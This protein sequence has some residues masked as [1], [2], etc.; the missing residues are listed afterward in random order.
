MTIRKIYI[1]LLLLTLAATTFAQ[2]LLV[3]NKNGLA[4]QWDLADSKAKGKALF[5]VK[6]YKPL[7]LLGK[8]SSDVNRMPQSDSPGRS[9]TEEIPLNKTELKFQLSLKTKIIDNILGEKLGGD[10]WGGYTQTSYLQLFNTNMSRPFRE[11]NYE[12]ELIFIV[13]VKYRL[14]GLG[15]VFL[16]V[17]VNH[18]SNGRSNPLSRSWNRIIAQVALEGKHTSVVFKPWWRIQESAEVD[19]NP[20]IENYVGRGELLLAYNK[21]IHHLSG[22]AR[23]SMNF[24]NNNH[25]SVQIDYSIKIKDNLKFHTQFFTGYGESLIDFNHR[26]TIIGIGISLTDW[27]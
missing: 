26:Q 12:P 7:Y 21:G 4:E 17:G 15:G 22:I 27:R 10:L 14:F 9:S 6:Q 2:N 23:H 25:G 24:G 8:L 13:P 11:S 20:G 5:V 19:D 16:G 18:Q 1:L 3:D